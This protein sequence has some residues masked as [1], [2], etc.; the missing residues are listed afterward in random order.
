M[1]TLVEGQTLLHDGRYRF[2]RRIGSGT[3]AVIMRCVALDVQQHCHV[4]IKCVR[5]LELNALGE[6]EAAA[7]RQVNDQ[8]VDDCCA[9]V[10]LLETF[11]EQGH[12]C[13]VLELLGPPVLDVG[14]WGPWRQAPG[15]ARAPDWTQQLFKRKQ[16]RSSLP[17]SDSTSIQLF[18][19]QK[20]QETDAAILLTPSLPLVEVRQMAVHLC[21]ALAFLH[22]QG[23]IHA[24][25]KPENVVRSNAEAPVGSSTSQSPCSSPVKLVDFG[26]C[27]DA[28]ELAAYAEEQTSEGFDVQT[29]TY[30]APE[31]AAGLLLC[32]AMDM[33]SLG[34]LLLECVSGKPLFTLPAL[35]A[36]VQQRSNVTKVEND[37]LLEQIEDTV[38][39]GVPLSSACAPYLSAAR[40]QE[41]T[42]NHRKQTIST[43]LKTRLE[44]AAPGNPHFQDFI[45]SL[46]DVNPATRVTAKQALFHPFLQDFFPFRTVFAQINTEVDRQHEPVGVVFSA[47]SKR[48]AKRPR[49]CD[50]EAEIRVR[51]TKTIERAASARSKD[52]RQIL[53]LI[54]RDEPDRSS[55]SPR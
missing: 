20:K 3:F 28:S 2:L 32:S 43:S 34:C 10:R 47:G 27:L 22:D 39:N 11:E 26:N 42:D 31:V 6:R 38:T 36:S 24:D 35:D 44:A 25:V 41:K 23:L 16:R 33:W 17:P 53:K 40:Y 54:P 12:F 55:L 1:Q 7:L 37:H 29:V 21:G 51:K 49:A 48:K 9:V 5:Q 13:L 18:E 45:C 52:L 46:L 8:D 30:R 15:A 50:V 19:A 4:A 14:L